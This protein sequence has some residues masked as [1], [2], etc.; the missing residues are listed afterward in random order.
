[1][2]NRAFLLNKCKSDRN[3]K[4]IINANGWTACYDIRKRFSLAADSA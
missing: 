3:G 1:L 4:A 2:S